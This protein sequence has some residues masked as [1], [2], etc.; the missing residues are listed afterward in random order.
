VP[1]ANIE[2]TSLRTILIVDD[3][4]D[5]REIWE[6]LFRESGF[7]V[8]VAASVAGGLAH[9]RI[10]ERIDVLLT[11]Y[12]LGDGTG[13]GML[14]QADEEGLLRGTPA[15]LCTANSRI[16]SSAYAR[17]VHKPVGIDEMI[18]HVHQLLDDPRFAV[19]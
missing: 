9:L 7:R 3:D 12:G 4:D 11:D 17:V 1:K 14:R 15:I 8:L 13:E 5:T 18:A 6:L 16:V 19:A 10:G 2:K